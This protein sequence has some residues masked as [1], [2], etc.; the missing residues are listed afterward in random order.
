M[1]WLRLQHCRS[2]KICQGLPAKKR[3]SGGISHF[4]SMTYREPTSDHPPTITKAYAIAVRSRRYWS[5]RALGKVRGSETV[6]QALGRGIQRGP[7][8]D[9]HRAGL[10]RIEHD[11]A[12]QAQHRVGL[13]DRRRNTGPAV[14]KPYPANGQTASLEASKAQAPLACQQ[15]A[16]R[17]VSKAQIDCVPPTMSAC[18]ELR[19]NSPRCG[20]SGSGL[21]KVVN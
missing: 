14:G 19:V 9:I 11:S 2:A 1:G 10:R 13:V 4:R 3:F 17:T 21:S 7:V 18:C 12:S 20:S 16:R 15:R 6:R 5:S 8:R